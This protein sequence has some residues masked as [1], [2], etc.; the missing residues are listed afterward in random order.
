MFL[1][2]TWSFIG[3]TALFAIVVWL[4]VT[5][6]K[7]YAEKSKYIKYGMIIAVLAVLS[8]AL[9]KTKDEPIKSTEE[10]QFKCPPPSSK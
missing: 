10:L 2:S 7:H 4:I 9:Y 5:I 3:G 6:T 1:M 8:W